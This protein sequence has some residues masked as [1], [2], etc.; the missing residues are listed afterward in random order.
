ML[1]SRP[2]LAPHSSCMDTRRGRASSHDESGGESGMVCV[3]EPAEL[4]CSDV[5]VMVSSCGDRAEK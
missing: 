5:R 1:L 4:M 3:A 2:S